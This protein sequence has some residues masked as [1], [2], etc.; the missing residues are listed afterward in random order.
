MELGRIACGVVAR[1]MHLDHSAVLLDA[2][3]S[4]RRARLHRAAQREQAH[5]GSVLGAGVLLRRCAQQS[6]GLGFALGVEHAQIAQVG[7][8]GAQ[9][10]RHADIELVPR[11]IAGQVQR[12]FLGKVS[13][14]ILRLAA[15]GQCAQQQR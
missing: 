14:C 6:V 15:G 2:D 4:L 10:Y 11:P 1:R 9:L 5:F 13:R 3:V 7:M 12:Q 8:G